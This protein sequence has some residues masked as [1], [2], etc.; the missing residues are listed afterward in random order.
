MA[1]VTILLNEQRK[2]KDDTFPIVI[3]IANNGKR[4]LIAT[5]CSV[6]KKDWDDKNK[7]VKPSCKDAHRFNALI[8]D[9]RAEVMDQIT[10]SELENR[11]I[12]LAK[13]G[14]PVNDSSFSKYIEERKAYF[15]AK[16][17]VTM[18]YK[19]AADIRE[20]EAVNKGEVYFTDITPKFLTEL[21]LYFRENKNSQNT[22]ARKF[23]NLRT[24]YEKAMLE[25]IAP[26][27]N[28]FKL[29]KYKK[30][31]V[32]RQKLT[33]DEI[34]V[35]EQLTLSPNSKLD[36]AR[37]MFLFSFYC[38]GMRFE[39]CLKLEK[40]QIVNGKINY[41]MNKGL[42]YRSIGIH[43]KLEA[44][45]NKYINTGGRYLFPLMEDREYSKEE[46]YHLK[47]SRNA[48]INKMLKIIAES[49]GIFSGLSF[50]ISKHSF[51]FISKQKGVDH[52]AM[53]DALGHS[54]YAVME[55]Y[56]KSLDDD[57]IDEAVRGV[58]D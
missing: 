4:K 23:K 51:A 19:C 21:E 1:T 34:K 31:P 35:L 9:K 7:K 22:I 47:G 37:D 14:K 11:Q 24:H 30:E 20:M 3:R 52:H 44:I 28:P 32:K 25:E 55:S 5:D 2:K 53:K 16:G 43:P 50:H 18:K 10:K 54:T 58:F 45:V 39:N 42:K 40:Q 6:L 15:E 49:S 36:L 57:Y 8:E 38:Q 27:P 26:Y 13:L 56:L 46:F 41:Q 33:S 29:V 12:N 17:N 48:E